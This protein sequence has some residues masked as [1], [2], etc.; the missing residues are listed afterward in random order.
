LANEVPYLIEDLE[1]T[2]ARTAELQSILYFIKNQS[3]ITLW[4]NGR[5]HCRPRSSRPECRLLHSRGPAWRKNTAGTVE[6]KIQPT[7]IVKA[8]IVVLGLD[9]GG[10]ASH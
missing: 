9:E 1:K 8:K 3:E 4:C 10:S 7:K 6:R 2:K 5:D